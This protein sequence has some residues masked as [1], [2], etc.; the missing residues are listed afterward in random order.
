[1]LLS[2]LFPIVFNK[3]RERC[4]GITSSSTSR[5]NRINS[6]TLCSNKQFSYAF[7]LTICDMTSSLQYSNM[8]LK[9][10]GSDR[11]IAIL[12]AGWW[13]IPTTLHTYRFSRAVYH[14][15][16]ENWEFWKN[17]M[18]FV[19]DELPSEAYVHTKGI[20]PKNEKCFKNVFFK[21]V[22]FRVSAHVGCWT[23]PIPTPPSGWSRSC[24]EPWTSFKPSTRRPKSAQSRST[25]TQG[26]SPPSLT[27]STSA[28]PWT[29]L[30]SSGTAWLT[31]S[32]SI[33]R[34]SV[35]VASPTS[36]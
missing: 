7:H 2:L 34:S 14:Y 5:W 21:N 26:T 11:D 23:W 13:K 24:E 29:T 31:S 28:V 18:G 1:M 12:S 25:S 16:Y 10:A 32:W 20:S 17:E 19:F 6:H 4:V 33:S 22:F 8:W 30:T 3:F 15:L 35:S 36:K 9:L 27:F